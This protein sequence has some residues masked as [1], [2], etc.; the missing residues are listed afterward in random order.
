MI[1]H[2]TPRTVRWFVDGA[3]TRQARGDLT[4]EAFVVG[5]TG[6]RSTRVMPP[7]L[8]LDELRNL[9]MPILLLIGQREILY[10]SARAIHRA[11]QLMPQIQ[12]EAIPDAS[13]FLLF[14][15]P[16]KVNQAVLRFL[17]P[18]A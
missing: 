5:V 4:I 7:S 17:Q 1:I 6:L 16:E 12:A 3:T 10:D 13:H 18:S 11:R 14:D 8:P 2:P 9:N 15:Q